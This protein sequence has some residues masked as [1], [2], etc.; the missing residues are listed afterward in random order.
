[1][2]NITAILK[3]NHVDAGNDIA[4]LG[5][6]QHHGCPTPLLDWSFKFQNALFFAMDGLQPKVH[7]TE[8]EDYC[9]VCLV[10]VLVVT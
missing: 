5:Y 9:S 10:R 8:I 7:D 2:K 1:G 4:V 3:E 6:L